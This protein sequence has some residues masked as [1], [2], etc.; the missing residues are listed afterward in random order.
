MRQPNHSVCIK[1]ASSMYKDVA[2]SMMMTAFLVTD[3]S[4]TGQ[5]LGSKYLSS[6]SAKSR[7]GIS[8]P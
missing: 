3:G 5:K 2:S 4:Y 7:F 8:T 1:Y 6:D